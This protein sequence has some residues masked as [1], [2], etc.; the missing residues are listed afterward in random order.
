MADNMRVSSVTES[1]APNLSYVNQLKEGDFY[2]GSS[3][4][5]DGVNSVSDTFYQCDWAKWHAYYL[6]IPIFAAMID[7]LVAWVVGKGFKGKDADKLKNIRGMGKDDPNSIFENLMRV[8]L[9]CGDS[10]GEIIKD[11]AGRLT[12]LKPLNP[13]NVRTVFNPSGILSRYDMMHPTLKI[14]IQ[15]FKPKEIFHLCWN[16]LADETHGKGLAERVES[17]IS[18]IKQVTE[19]LATRFHMIVKPLRVVEANTDDETEL[20]NLEEKL[21]RA[22]TKCSLIVIPK[23]SVVPQDSATNQNA[24][25]A[26]QHLNNL[27]RELVTSCGCPEV[28]L[29]WSVGTTEAS[30]K[31]VY[32]SFQ[33]PTERKDK[34]LEEQIRLQ[35]GL[36]I[37]FEFPASLE[38]AMTSAPGGDNP[39]VSTP[40]KDNAKAGKINNVMKK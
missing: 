10:H 19:D 3:I 9:I 14:P 4:N 1:T 7:T 17:I 40:A 28:I 36:E 34:F 13:G 12:N 25:D 26:L 37:E 30:A 27:I 38:P 21:V 16:R 35:L 24:Q 33:Q 39:K 23:G 6:E 5:T 11:K 22:Y 8:A 32:L 18:R 2:Q 29:G 15:P 31:I 20:A